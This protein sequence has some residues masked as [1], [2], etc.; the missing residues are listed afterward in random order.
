MRVGKNSLEGECTESLDCHKEIS[1]EEQ[2]VKMGSDT[3]L[4]MPRTWS[5]TQ[6]CGFSSGY[7]V[8]SFCAGYVDLFKEG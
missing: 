6:L 7:R 3:P 8:S 5:E 4:F 1:E 2:L